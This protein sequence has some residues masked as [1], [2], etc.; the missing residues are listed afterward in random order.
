[1]AN[2]RDTNA[3]EQGVL[4]EEGYLIRTHKLLTSSPD[5][6]LTELVANA[7]D[8]GATLV[9][10]TIPERCDEL[11]II[12]DNGCGMSEKDFSEH[13]MTLSYNR[14]KHQ[15][16]WASTINEPRS[17]LAYGRNG[18]GRHGLLC[19]GE[20]YTVMTTQRGKT[21]EFE[22]SS[23]IDKQPLTIISKKIQDAQNVR[24][25]GTELRVK[26]RHNRPEPTRILNTLSARFVTDPTFKIFVNKNTISIEDLTKTAEMAT[27]MVKPNIKLEIL[28]FFLPKLNGMFEKSALTP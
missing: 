7:W 25:H 18:I 13:W 21:C 3:L 23:L 16:K 6:A 1:M 10:I 2:D 15:G 26:V 11:L 28:R 5:I 20:V 24:Q 17:R 12:K 9:E 19:F 14:Q 8:A 22:I 27:V 4:F